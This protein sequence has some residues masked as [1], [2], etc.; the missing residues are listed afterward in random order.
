MGAHNH[1]LTTIPVSLMS[2]FDSADTRHAYSTHAFCIHEGEISK[3][4]QKKLNKFKKCE[5]LLLLLL[6]SLKNN[7]ILF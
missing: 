1:L 4:M 2:S 6:I 5:V 3:H 7:L